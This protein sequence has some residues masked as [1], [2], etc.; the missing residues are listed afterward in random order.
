MVSVNDR[1]P[2]LFDTD[3]GSD[4]DDAVALAYLL[5][6]PRCDLVGIT[7]VSGEPQARAS[8]ADALCRAAGR[9]NIPIHS[10]SAEPFLVEQRQPHAPQKSILERWPHRSDFAPCSAVPFMQDLIRSRP[11]EIT[12]LAVGPLTNVGLLFVVDPEI[13]SLLKRLVL[14]AGV[15]TTDVAG[16]PRA[17]WNVLLD[18]H[19]AA[20]VFQSPVAE[21][22]A[23]GL[24]VTMRCSLEAEECRQRFQGPVLSVVAEMAEVWFQRRPRIVFHDPLA[25]AALF[26]PDL[27]TYETGRIEVELSSPRT[28]GMTHWQADPIGPHKVAK[29]VDAERFFQRYFSVTT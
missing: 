15:Y 19:A 3:I 2:V 25:A 28:A 10:G 6:E 12:L 8:L 29:G 26:E 1:V 23:Y 18:P 11:G 24:D 16:A 27:C 13:P 17:E 9:T 22:V 4:I 20:R 14:M 7:T 5:R 21:L